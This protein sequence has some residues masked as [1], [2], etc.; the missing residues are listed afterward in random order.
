MSNEILC[1]ETA[2]NSCL[3]ESNKGDDN[4]RSPSLSNNQD[5][6]NMMDNSWESPILCGNNTMKP[7]NSDISLDDTHALDDTHTS[8]NLSKE[9][10]THSPKPK[11]PENYDT[12]NLYKYMNE[13]YNQTIKNKN[14]YD[15]IT[16]QVF[17]LTKRINDIGEKFLKFKENIAGRVLGNELKME[18]LEKKSAP[19][20][21]AIHKKIDENKNR[22]G[23]IT[24]FDNVSK[25]IGEDIQSLNKK[26]AKQQEELKGLMENTRDSSA[27]HRAESTTIIANI[28]PQHYKP[29]D[30]TNAYFKHDVIF[31][32]DS[33]LGHLDPNRMNEK[34]TC[35]KFFCP[36]L[37]HIDD[38]MGEATIH[39]QPH[40]I[41]IHCGT[42][43]FTNKSVQTDKLEEGYIR[44]LVKLRNLFPDAKIVISSILPREEFY[45]YAPIQFI[46]DFLQGVCSSAPNLSFM[47]NTNIGRHLL[48]DNK[49]IDDDGFLTLL[50]NIRYTLFCKIPRVHHNTSRNKYN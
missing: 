1:D 7:N 32:V 31:L 47:R 49:H 26:I 10:N 46:N 33:N 9:L 22:I 6:G 20:T 29:V 11:E 16:K 13:I 43:H 34:Y 39:Q 25:R 40:T 44:I 21:K 12:P 2:N 17:D 50:S 35:A 3:L 38:L 41:F 28:R 19:D 8:D 45:L 4:C 5:N 48:V 15:I 14:N 42:N 23:N 30:Y 24:N 18:K 36:T 37:D 27:D